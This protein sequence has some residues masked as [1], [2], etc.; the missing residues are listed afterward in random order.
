M[1]ALHPD[2]GEDSNGLLATAARRAMFCAEMCTSCAAACIAEPMDMRQ[3][4]RSYLDC[5]DV[6][7]ATGRLAV[8]RT[9]RN[10]EAV[11]LL[12][13]ACAQVCELCA[14]QSASHDH[15]HCQ[16]CSQMCR[17]CAADCRTS[18]ATIN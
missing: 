5:A 8:R 9:G 14:A 11:K 4:L 3:C 18:L 10:I 7:A 16:L 17:E 12:L 2:V 15:A 6:C 13:E 1:I